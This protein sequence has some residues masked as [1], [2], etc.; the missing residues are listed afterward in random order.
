MPKKV[1][2]NFWATV[3]GIISAIAGLVAAVAG[4]LG[5]LW[6]QGFLSGK[7]DDPHVNPHVGEIEPLT[8][9]PYGIELTALTDPANA[10]LATEQVKTIA[11]KGAS[12][13]LYK[14]RTNKGTIA[15]AP[16]VL[17][18]DSTVASTDRHRYEVNDWDPELVTI[19]TWCPN[20]RRIPSP[21]GV[22]LSI[23]VLDCT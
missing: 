7:R 4:L 9:L 11:P 20:P 12:I 2:S 17:Y 16:V 23:P 18:T 21:T 14:R 6:G 10:V 22:P 19:S 8:P 13:R 3:P 15:W 1:A 5:V